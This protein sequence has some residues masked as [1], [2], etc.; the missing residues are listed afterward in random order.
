MS[1]NLTKYSLAILFT[2]ACFFSHSCVKKNI[3]DSIYYDNGT[4]K[5]MV[6]NC[7]N[8]DIEK[9]EYYFYENGEIKSIQRLNKKGLFEGEQLWFYPT[10]RLDKKIIFSNH[11]KQGNAY[12]FYDTTGALKN[13]RFYQNGNES[14]YGV[15]YWGDSMDIMKASLHFNDSG[16]IFYKKNFDERGNFISEEGNRE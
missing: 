7:K 9:T 5:R 16:Q 11:K 8:S 1:I 14:L 4:I 2:I 15:D 6:I 13:F 12:F 3:N 10:G